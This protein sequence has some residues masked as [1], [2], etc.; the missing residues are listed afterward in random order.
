MLEKIKS[1]LFGLAV[2]D[3]LGV[4]VEFRTRDYLKANPVENMIGHG[5]WN[6]PPGIWSDDS[7]LAFCLAESLTHGYDLKEI[8]FYFVQWKLNGFWSANNNRFDLGIATQY[9]IEKLISGI[10]PE[11]SGGTTEGDNGNGSL[12]RILPLVFYVKD[13]P[14]NE[15]YD[16]V[17]EV[18]SITHAHVR[19]VLSC[20]IF[21]DFAKHLLEGLNSIEAYQKMQNCVNEFVNEKRFDK[22]EIELFDRILKGNIQKER[23]TR[24]HSDE[25]VIHTLEASL[26]CLLNTSNYAD[27]TLKAVNLGEDTDTLGCVTGGLAGLLHGFENIPAPWISQIAR[28]NDIENL[29]KRLAFQ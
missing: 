22:S 21:I 6:Q 3:A 11:R 29:C 19:S 12:M 27:A 13:L 18:S 28:N 4:P 17:R 25:Y 1:A 23:E 24:I 5:T 2:G 7:S 15:T 10:S 14:H 16:R 20:F 8:A 26:W 9:A